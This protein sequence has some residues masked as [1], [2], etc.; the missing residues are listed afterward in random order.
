MFHFPI[1]DI[2][3]SRVVNTYTRCQ[4]ILSNAAGLD[5]SA[6]CLEG[7]ELDLPPIVVDVEVSTGTVIIDSPT[8]V[9]NKCPC[10]ITLTV[11]TGSPCVQQMNGPMC[12]TSIAQ[13]QM[14]SETPTTLG[15]Y[16]MTKGK[17]PRISSSIQPMMTH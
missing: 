16:P 5:I 7:E 3:P 4:P 9:T 2:L 12:T 13:N 14:V 6:I 1:W 10:T 17:S 8:R 15:E 11:G